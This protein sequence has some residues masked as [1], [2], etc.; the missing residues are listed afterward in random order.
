M[1]T[2]SHI[3]TALPAPVRLRKYAVGIFFAAPT[4]AALKKAIHKRRVFV[5][6][7]AATSDTFVRGGE[8]IEL[9]L[10]EE[11]TPRRRLVFPLTVLYEDE[12]IAAIHKPAGILVSGNTFKTITAALPQNLRRGTLPDAVKPQ[13][14]HRLD[15]PTTGI[16]LVGKT[17]G[18][19]RALN[20]L[21]AD[22]AIEKTYYAVTMGEMPAAGSIDAPVDERSA[23]SRYRVIRS[24]PSR[25]FG[26]LNLVE[27]Q[28]ETGRRH[29]L[30]KHLAGIGSPILG[31]RDYGKEGLLL[32][33]KGMYLHAYSLRF[34]HPFTEEEMYLV[35]ELPAGFRKIFPEDS[36]SL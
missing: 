35:D 1:S 21:F 6:G 36:V 10:P 14:A 9:I 31:D 27:L 18:G 34:T 19:I 22:K 12:R 3:V 15:Y 16:V 32:K 23:R 7:V 4:G 8:R 11:T 5:D 17:N 25:R 30:R 29:Q 13:P 2:Q 20:K 28:P 33:G 26:V 24:V